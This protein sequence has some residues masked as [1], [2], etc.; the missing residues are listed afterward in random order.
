MARHGLFY[1]FESTDKIEFGLP[2]D[3]PVHPHIIQCAGKLINLDTRDCV[4][5]FSVY[6][7]QGDWPM[8]P[9]AL[10]THGITR[11]KANALGFLEEE[12]AMWLYDLWLR[13]VVRIAHN[14]KFDARMMRIALKRYHDHKDFSYSDQWKEGKSECTMMMSTD[15]CKLPSPRGGYKWPKLT[16]AYEHFTGRKLENAHDAM[17]DVDACIE[18]YFIMKDAEA[19]QG[20]SAA[21]A[22][23]G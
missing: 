11:D 22:F 4:A 15:I 20:K 19:A 2:S 5:S 17:A 16:E 7:L 21:G 12:V 8:S 3:D 13:S 9:G 14:E 18:I 6:A 23:F 10:E 1:D